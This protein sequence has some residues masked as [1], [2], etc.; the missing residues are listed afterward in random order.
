MRVECTTSGY[1]TSC[2]IERFRPD[3]V[4][5][6]WSMGARTAQD[7]CNHLVQD[8]RLPLTRLVLT[9]PDERATEMCESEIMGWLRKPFTLQQLREF[10][11]SI[12]DSGD[13]LRKQK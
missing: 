6:D 7:L 10:L 2:T 4:V 8:P 1:E 9:S 13:S 5:V 3:Y 12:Q 11:Q